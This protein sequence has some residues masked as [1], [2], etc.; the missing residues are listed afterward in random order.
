MNICILQHV[1]FEGAGTILPFFSGSNHR[2][3]MVHLY[4]GESLPSPKWPDL[5]IVMGGPMGV[6]DEVRFPWLGAE[7][8][9]I[10]QVID[11]QTWVLGVCLGAQLIANVLGAAVTKN[12]TPEIGW[13]P[14]Q[15][16]PEFQATWL[17]D[18]F[19]QEF[20]AF[21]WHSDTF[22]IPRNAQPLGSSAACSRQG[23]LWNERVLGL[24]FHLEFT[25]ESTA[26]LAEKCADELVENR[27]IQTPEQMLSSSE[28]FE[29]AN[30]LM[31][32]ILAHIQSEILANIRL[33]DQ[34]AADCHLL[35]ETES[36]WILLNKNAAI[37]WFILVPKGKFRDLDDI[38]E[39]QRKLLF[40]FADGISDFLRS[41]FQSEKINV[42]ALGN[43]VPQLHLHVIGRT[44]S[45]CC[46]PNP[47]WGNLTEERAWSSVEIDAIR[48]RI[49]SLALLG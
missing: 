17:N 30:G 1:P 35:Q 15:I 6:G 29:R 39:E 28:R 9:F 19:G 23:F 47:V 31:E 44:I 13:F 3:R 36:L 33:N 27:W 37:P 45:D 18:L 26:L 48:Q 38:S 42:A 34:L 40:R 12:R 25:P 46:W 14:I 43:M 21:H 7:K 41:E 4:S 16:N 22:E 5:L 24:Q 2:V 8:K 11:E 32:K 49:D 20:D 10:E